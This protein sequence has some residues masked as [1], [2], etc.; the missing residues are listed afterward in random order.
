MGVLLGITLDVKSGVSVRLVVE[1]ETVCVLVGMELASQ[2][3]C[4]SRCRD[5]AGSDR[6]GSDSNNCGP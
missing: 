5:G 6:W 3:A 4:V 1:G 2:C